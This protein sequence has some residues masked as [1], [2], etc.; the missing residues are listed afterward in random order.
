MGDVVFT[1]CRATG[2]YI[3]NSGLDN[4][5]SHCGIYGLLTIEKILEGKHMKK[6]VTATLILYTSIFQTL[7][8]QLLGADDE[9]AAP[10]ASHLLLI[11]VPR[12]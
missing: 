9:Y 5:F 12:C 10:T 2:K 7:Y 3:D 4:L 11:A 8:D 6:C 1:V